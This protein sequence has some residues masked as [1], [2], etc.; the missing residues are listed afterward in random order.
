MVKAICKEFE[1]K[2]AVYFSEWFYSTEEFDK[3]ESLEKMMFEHPERQVRQLFKMK[4]N[5]YY[6]EE[7][8]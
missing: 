6:I 1:V 7:I 5:Q 4:G 2:Q 8:E 3:Y